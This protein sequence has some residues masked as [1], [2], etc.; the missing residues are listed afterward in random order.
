HL[1][2]LALEQR[3]DGL[4]GLRR[5]EGEDPAKGDRDEWRHGASLKSGIILVFVRGAGRFQS[6]YAVVSRIPRGRDATY[7]QVARLA[8]LPGHARLVGFAMAALPDGTRVPWHRV[9]NA[10]GACSLRQDGVGHFVQRERLRRER[11]RFED[12]RIRLEQFLWR[13]AGALRPG[14]RLARGEQSA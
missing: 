1:L 12:G 5:R 13:P 8:G 6:I 11:V 3:R 9:V 14:A 7:G 10:R 2:G 4:L